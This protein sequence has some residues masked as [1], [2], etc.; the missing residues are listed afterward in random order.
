MITRVTAEEYDAALLH[1]PELCR[2]FAAA[3]GDRR[4]AAA[5]LAAFR[6]EA[7]A[8]LAALGATGEGRRRAEALAAAIRARLAGL[9]GV[10]RRPILLEDGSAI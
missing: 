1:S 9:A 2:P 7:A 3:L 6:A 8:P 10:P 5:C 4:P